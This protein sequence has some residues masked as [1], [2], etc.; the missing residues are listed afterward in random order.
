MNRVF[1]D[2]GIDPAVNEVISDF[3]RGK[4]RHIV[5]D[6][7]VAALLCPRDH[8]IGT[9][10]LVLDTGYY[11]TFNRGN[12]TLVSVAG[13]P[14]ERI[15]PT[16]LQLRS[17]AVYDVDLIVSALGFEAFRGAMERIDLRNAE[18]ASVPQLWARGPRT[19]L[20]LMTA[21]FQIYPSPGRQPLVLAN[22]ALMNE[23][24]DFTAALIAHMRAGRR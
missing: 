14:I 17:G 12:V 9:R 20:G 24:H 6:P 2:Q 1:A 18:D 22:M 3:V 23:Q 15:T 8:P 13:D 21:G 5:R 7:D 10:R 4:I 19:L 16:G 11:E